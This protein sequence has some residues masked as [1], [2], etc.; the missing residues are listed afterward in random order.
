MLLAAGCVAMACVACTAASA[1]AQQVDASPCPA[2]AAA[3]PP[4]QR[5]P[6]PP[7]ASPDSAD[8]A[9]A[10]RQQPLQSSTGQ[11]LVDVAI[12]ASASAREVRFARQPEIR[13]RLC[14]GLDS[15]RVVERR[16]IP[17]P[18]VAGTTY[19]D[20][21]VAVEILGRIDAACLARRL[22]VGPVGRDTTR[23]GVA[24]MSPDCASVTIGGAAAPPGSAASRVDPPP[25]TDG[26]PA[27]RIPVPARP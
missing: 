9:A 21:Y 25:G 26:A 8:P 12:Y 19:R 4:G 18:V 7:G 20:V 27:G 14:G 22:G 3:T 6:G 16:N 10:A 17:S 1:G 15:I 11:Q 5:S 24:P 2:T 13:V 23:A